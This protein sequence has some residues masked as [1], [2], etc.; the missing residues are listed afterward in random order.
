MMRH[1]D[2]GIDVFCD[3]TRCAA[4]LRV[5]PAGAGEFRGAAERARVYGWRAYADRNRRDLCPA[6]RHAALK[7]LTLVR[8]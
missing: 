2:G 7:R 4:A 3:E 1:R 8:A 6:H 5:E